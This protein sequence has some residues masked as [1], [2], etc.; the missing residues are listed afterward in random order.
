MTKQDIRKS[1]KSLFKE[2]PASVITE[3]SREIMGRVEMLPQFL[4]SETVAIYR[5]LSDEVQTCDFIAKWCGPKTILLP[6]MNG[7]TIVL[8]QYTEGCEMKVAAYNILE[9]CG[10]VHTGRVDMI[11]VPGM[12]F[13]RSGNRLGRGKGF[14]DRFF[15]TSP[16]KAGLKVGVCFGF[17]LFDSLPAEQHDVKMDIVIAGKNLPLHFTE[18]CR[19]F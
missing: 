11:I 10:K 3:E 15:S 9:P 7:E 13:D 18:K 17:Q 4:E 6:V 1:V 8:K 2:L 16:G 14:Y 12:A 19:N 5:S